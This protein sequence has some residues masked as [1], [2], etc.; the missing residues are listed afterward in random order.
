MFILGLLKEQRQ[1][2]KDKKRQEVRG[3]G[4]TVGKKTGRDRRKEDR[5]RQG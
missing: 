3:Q 5:D 4:E 2:E 1:Q